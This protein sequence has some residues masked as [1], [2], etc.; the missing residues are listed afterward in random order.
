M[1]DINKILQGAKKS[2]DFV[3]KENKE[4]KKIHW[5]YETNIPA[6]PETSTTQIFWQ[7]KRILK[8]KTTKKILKSCVWRGD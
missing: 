1:S 5:K 3:V 8:A 6:V 7:G 4:L 2:Y